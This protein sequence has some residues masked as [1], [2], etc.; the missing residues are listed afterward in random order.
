MKNTK[1]VMKRIIIVITVIALTVCCGAI[2]K[3]GE[4]TNADEWSGWSTTYPTKK[5]VEI[6]SRKEYR[7]KNRLV[8]KATSTPATPS[9]YSLESSS[10]INEYTAWGSWSG[11]ST[12]AVGS[13]SLRDVQSQNGYRV[14]AFKCNSCGRRDAFSGGCSRCGKTLT[15]VSTVDTVT[16][17]QRGYLNTDEYG[18]KLTT[19]GRVIINGVS[20]YFELNGCSNGE[21]QS[22]SVSGSGKGQVIYTIYRYRTRTQYSEYRYWPLEFSAWSTEKATESESKVVETRTVYRYRLKS[23][24]STNK[25]TDNKRTIY[26]SSYNLNRGSGKRA[27]KKDANRLII[28][29]AKSPRKKTLFVKW[30]KVKGVSGYQ[31]FIS[32]SK[33]FKNRTLKNNY[34]KRKTKFVGRGIKS[35][36]VF[37]IKARTYKKKKGRI[38]YGKWS[39]VKRV[40][41]K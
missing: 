28:K 9:G 36:T 18:S 19:K 4:K 27:K 7:Y 17:Y 34:K 12:T 26:D 10:K 37:Y 21:P 11:W 29:K 22:R 2:E 3:N 35:G 13:N 24:I 14:Y 25:K 40:R 38:K 31:V 6:Q 41:I 30:K 32:K 20:W 5:N 15:W 33:K 39:K 23:S 8:K 16:G 1:R